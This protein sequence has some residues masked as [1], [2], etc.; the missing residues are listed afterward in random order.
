MVDGHGPVI[1]SFA[2]GILYLTVSCPKN[3]EVMIHEDMNMKEFVAKFKDDESI[4]LFL[5]EARWPR[6]FI[7]PNCG[8]NDGYR[9]SDGRTIQCTVC[10]KQKSITADTIFERSHIPLTDWFLAIWLVSTDKRGLSAL[11]LSKRLGIR[12]VSAWNMLRKIRVVMRER[13]L[14]LTLAGTIEMDEAFFGGKRK[15]P[16]PGA[17]P[18]EGKV[19]V[20]VLV[21]S[22]LEE[23][24][25]LVMK[26]IEDDSFENLQ[27]VI[28]E[29]VE[30]DPAGQLIVTD[31]LGRHHVVIS[32]G[33]QLK[34]HKM[35][36]SE[37]D[38]QMAWVSRAI[39]NA[40]ALFKGTFHHFCKKSI[41]AYLDEFCYRW[42]R[43]EKEN[44]IASHLAAACA[45]TSPC[46]KPR[47]TCSAP[48]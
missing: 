19:E 23:A 26:V 2:M 36:K 10:R 5:F 1:L 30:S 8:H 45:R 37:M 47:K 38:S 42:N 17:S 18:F 33:H 9:L 16:K 35:S 27:E 22:E 3:G 4:L 43:R 13:E 40:K 14:K 48:A 11:A 15:V 31:G 32:C 28:E 25:N 7:C 34:M 20:L 29:K 12:Y 46:P 41:Q 6:G 24:G 39:S 21:E 44:R